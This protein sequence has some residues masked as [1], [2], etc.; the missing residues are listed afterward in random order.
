MK[1]WLQRFGFRESRYERPNQKWVCGWRTEGRECPLGPDATGR[2][3]G[4]FQCVPARQGDRW[5]CTRLAALGGRCEEGPRPDGTCCRPIPPCQPVRSLR[6]RRG[7]VNW[8]TVAL[9]VGGL[10]FL[11]GG[12]DRWRFVSPGPLTLHHG[13]SELICSDCHV[14]VPRAAAH[15]VAGP[16]AASQPDA[17]SHLCLNCHNIGPNQFQPHGLAPAEL[18]PSSRK[19][20]T[21]PATARPATLALSSFL[22]GGPAPKA[23]GIRCV[24]CHSEHHGQDA[25]LSHLENSQCQICHARQ[26]VSFAKGHPLF[27]DFPYARRTRIIFD[28]ASHL[29]KHFDDPQF[30]ANA[31][32]TC[33]ACHEP[34]PAGR[35]ML[36]KDFQVSCANCH[37]R[38][39]EG[40]GRADAPGIAFFR[41]PGLDVEALESRVGPIGDWPTTADDEGKLTPFMQLLLSS[42]PTNRAALAMLARTDLFDLRNANTNTLAAAG[43][44]VWAIKELLY[45]LVTQGQSVLPG[46]LPET[47][48]RELSGPQLAS[49]AGQLP[50]DAIVSAQREWFPDLL[51]E[52]PRHRRGEKPDSSKPDGGGRSGEKPGAGAPDK[53]VSAEAWVAKGGWYRSKSDY[54]ICYR[55]TGHADAFVRGWLDLAAGG[56]SDAEKTA[57]NPVFK[58]LSSTKAPGYCNKCHSIDETPDRNLQVNWRPARP[59]PNEHLF[60]KFSHAAHFSL[61]DQR[62]CLTCHQLDSKAEYL[63]AFDNSFNPARFHSNFAPMKKTDC[64]SCHTRGASGDSCLQCHNYHVGNFAAT[65]SRPAQSRRLTDALPALK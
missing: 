29:A 50:M 37:A 35:K 11:L 45:D 60:T 53:P 12:P 27:S 32:T 15:P 6:A 44:I 20:E 48:Q 41:V 1:R 59:V 21:N 51:V 9:T 30:K 24:V 31:P 14:E 40:E 61:L 39:I 2:C 3:H 55:P 13:L 19:I 8:L 49:L 56:K 17:D 42:D 18:A 58:L 38:Q 63:T 25:D 4:N 16:G 62:G 43:R 47:L 54:A 52:V 23:G 22:V 65:M 5:N 34:D 64:S 33:T 57:L 28:H 46:R 36:V 26:F 7:L 10:A